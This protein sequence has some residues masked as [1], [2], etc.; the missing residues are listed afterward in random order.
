M[1]FSREKEGSDS[2]FERN[3]DNLSNFHENKTKKGELFLSNVTADNWSK[4]DPSNTCGDKTVD[5]GSTFYSVMSS[6]SEQIT[7]MKDKPVDIIGKKSECK[8]LSKSDSGFS[9]KIVSTMSGNEKSENKIVSEVLRSNV[10]LASHIYQENY[11]PEDDDS[12]PKIVTEMSITQAHKLFDYRYGAEMALSPISNDLKIE[13]EAAGVTSP[14]ERSIKKLR[15]CS[16]ANK[17]GVKNI[18]N[19]IK[20]AEYFSDD[21]YEDKSYSDEDEELSGGI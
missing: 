12:E 1:L 16:S 3:C 6:A 11:N 2:Y 13:F 21:D 9:E 20:N 4:M 19:L 15:R 14:L 7:D 18:S 8:S 5:S 17:K 10:S